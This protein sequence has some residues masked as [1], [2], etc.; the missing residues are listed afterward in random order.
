MIKGLIYMVG[1]GLGTGYAPVAP[2]T[3]GSLLA[4]LLF[5]LWPQASF[6]WL[7][8]AIVFFLLGVPVSTAIEKERGQDPSMVVIDEV[9]GQWLALIFLPLFN[10][11]IA[12]A[13]FLL[14]RLFDIWKPFP[15]NR[16]QSL[17][18]GWGIMVDDVLAGIY[19]NIVL[20]IVLRS[21]LLR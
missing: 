9:V 7:I 1:A 13:A 11:K 8:M 2:G 6:F 10:W 18:A 15:I 5:F 4:V 20:Q 19:A 21:G 17:R 12:L 14:F 3:A 16:S